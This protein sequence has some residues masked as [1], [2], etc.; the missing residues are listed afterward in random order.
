MISQAVVIGDQ[1]KYLSV[2]ITLDPEHLAE[3]AKKNQLQPQ[4][5][6]RLYTHTKIYQEI[7]HIVEKINPLFAQVEQIKRFTILPQ[8]LTIEGG[9]LT[10]TMKIKRSVVQKKYDAEIEAM[11][12]DA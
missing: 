12:H 10:P 3:F 11:Y 7:Q 2:L 8:E 1:R 9:E 4:G 6:G 5:D